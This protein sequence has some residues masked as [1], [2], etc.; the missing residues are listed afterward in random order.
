MTVGSYAAAI[1]AGRCPRCGGRM[2]PEWTTAHCP[3]CLDVIAER[4]RARRSAPDFYA[5]RYAARLA[6]TAVT[7]TC[8]E[9]PRPREPGVLRCR[10]CTVDGSTAS[11]KVYDA[12][13]AAGLCPKCGG[14]REGVAV[15]CDPC[16]VKQADRR[17]AREARAT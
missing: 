6:S 11:M 10:D 12:R 17:R 5:R 2:L 14:A 7:L 15:W 4:T 13:K 8:I 1:D 3:T 9:C 16:R